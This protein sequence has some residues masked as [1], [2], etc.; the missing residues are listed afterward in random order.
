[1]LFEQSIDH[2]RS[3]YADEVRLTWPPNKIFSS[4]SEESTYIANFVE[5][6]LRNLS[7]NYLVVSAITYIFVV[8]LLKKK[9]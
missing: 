9:W 8:N 4:L 3:Q 7:A 5:Y 1:M 2:T 6:L